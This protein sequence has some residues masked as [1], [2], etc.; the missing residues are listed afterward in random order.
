[1]LWMSADLGAFVA[2]ASISVDDD[3][4]LA[5]NG[6]PTGTSNRRIRV[7]MISLLPCSRPCYVLLVRRMITLMIGVFLLLSHGGIVPAHAHDAV[8]Q[9]VHLADEVDAVSDYHAVDSTIDHAVVDSGDSD[10]GTAK[11]PL[12][13]S[14]L[15]VDGAVRPLE[16]SSVMIATTSVRYIDRGHPR[17]TSTVVA[18]GLEPPTA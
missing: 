6:G 18:P 16:A 1:M 13:H 10:A 14:H 9:H 15:V 8:Q 3:K 2:G 7:G 12:S 11:S 17:P 4:R 5:M